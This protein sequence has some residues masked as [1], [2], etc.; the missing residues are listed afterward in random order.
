MVTFYPSG[1]QRTQNFQVLAPGLVSVLV[2]VIV[3][4]VLVLVLVVVV[5]VIVIVVVGM[6]IY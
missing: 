3:L 4:M 2:P 5:I 6:I 1:V